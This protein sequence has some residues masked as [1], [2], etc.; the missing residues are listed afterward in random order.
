MIRTE[1]LTKYYGRR[2]AVNDLSFTIDAHEVVGFLGLNGAGKSTTLRMLAGLLAPSWGKI[3]IDG[4]DLL[5][6]EGRHQ[7]TRIGFQP[8]RPPVYEGMRVGD[9]LRFAGRLR[10]CSPAWL[11]RRIPEVMEITGLG[12]QRDHLIGTL[13]HGFRQRVGIAQAI[14]HDPALVILDEPTGGL[15][16]VQVVEMREVIRQL[17]N[18][19]TVLL[20]SHNLPEISQ[21]CDRLIVVQNGELVAM[22]T[23]EALLAQRGG[24]KRWWI[25]VSGD[26]SVLHDVLHTPIGTRVLGEVGEIK[27]DGVASVRVDLGEVPPEALAQAIVERGLGLR[28]LQPVEGELEDLFFQLTEKKA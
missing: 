12:Q 23:E 15:D 17:K 9:Y 18:Q 16:P 24:H 1:A 10:S 5:S 6:E 4:L 14:V 13:S 26:R 27:S 3:S 8:E 2:C 19:H 21:T 25:E 20:S 28:R 7:R 11:E 22:G